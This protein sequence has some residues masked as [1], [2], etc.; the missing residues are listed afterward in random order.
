MGGL[1]PEFPGR[2]AER[3]ALV[4]DVLG[5]RAAACCRCL[6][7][8]RMGCDAALC[9]THIQ[10]LNSQLATARCSAHKMMKV[11]ELKALP[12]RCVWEGCHQ[13]FRGDMP[14]G[15]RWLL[16]YWAPEPQLA[17]DASPDIEWAV[18]RPCALHTSRN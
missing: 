6:A 9:P 4:I 10:K 11:E 3:L 5:A 13:N 2:H 17:V 18:M 12:V 16:T 7:R 1:S 15:W 8:Y 14:K